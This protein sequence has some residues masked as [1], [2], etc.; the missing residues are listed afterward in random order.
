[1]NAARAVAT[2][3]LRGLREGRITVV[4][5]DWRGDFGPAGA[6]SRARVTVHDGSRFW[7][8]MA[9]GSTP[10]LADTFADDAWDCDDLVTLVRIFAREMPRLDGRS[11]RCAT[12]S[13]ASRATHAAPRA[14]TSRPTTTSA[15][16]S[17]SCS[18]TRP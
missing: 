9:R 8:A 3:V 16:T 11:H 10:A 4:E 7:P 2:T 5:G 6:T 14:G 1:V 12:R 17:S 13:R 18:S 15:T